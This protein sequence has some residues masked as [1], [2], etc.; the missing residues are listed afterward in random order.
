MIFS[1]SIIMLN[2]QQHPSEPFRA[3]LLYFQNNSGDPTAGFLCCG[4]IIFVI[5]ILAVAANSDAKRQAAVLAGARDAYQNSLIKLKTNPTSADL[6][7][8][9]LNLG[10]TY[11]NLTRNKSGVTVFDEVALMNDINAACAGAAVVSER[12]ST[13]P[14]KTIE[15]RL[16]RLAELKVQ[17]LIDEEEFATRRQKI[18]D[19]I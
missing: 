15:E 2:A 3:L 14:K 17:G 1:P 7:Q 8:K 12:K 6:R 19:E 9:T 5:I 13:S 18:L 4:G 16:E 11:S 10:R